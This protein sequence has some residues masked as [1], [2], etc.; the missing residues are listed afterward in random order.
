MLETPRLLSSSLPS[1]RHLYLLPL[2]SIMP[3]MAHSLR[4]TDGV[5]GDDDDDAVMLGDVKVHCKLASGNRGGCCTF[6]QTLLS[7]SRSPVP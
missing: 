1:E 6:K 2:G 3:K 7:V 4:D 5:N